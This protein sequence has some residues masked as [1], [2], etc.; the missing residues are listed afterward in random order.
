MDLWGKLKF[1]YHRWRGSCKTM[2]GIVFG[3]TP[4]HQGKGVEAAI[5]V[6]ASKVVQNN[7]SIPY[8]DLQMNWIGDFNP[9]MMKVVE[10]VGSRIYKTHITYRYLFDRTKEFKRAPIIK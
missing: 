5:V 6:A 1:V 7:S 9:K 8:Q 3:I 4:E 10:Q 2:Y